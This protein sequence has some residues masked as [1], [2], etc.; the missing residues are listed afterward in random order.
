MLTSH[1]RT[2]PAPVRTARAARF[3]CVAA[4]ALAGCGP[5]A[6]RSDSE[7]LRVAAA[8]DLQTVLPE[9]VEAFARTTGSRR[10]ELVFG[11]S[12]Q[13]ARQLAQGAPVDLFLSADRRFVDELAA[14]GILAADSTRD[15]T[16]GTLCLVVHK[17]ALGV[18]HELADLC[19]EKVGRVAIA[20]PETAPYGRAG[21]QALM[22]A[23]LWDRLEPKI[24]FAENVRQAY[25]F[26][27]TGNAEGGLVGCSIAVTP[28]VSRIDIDPTLHDPIIQRLGRVRDSRHAEAARAFSDFLLGPEA[29]KIFLDHGFR[30]CPDSSAAGGH[31]NSP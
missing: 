1:D 28:E 16:Q 2:V 25:Q 30:P 20:N 14:Q 15:Y 18:V 23:G 3:F 7:P 17:S 6:S 26:V 13:L 4:L 21:K 8:A 31:S 11:A 19:D 5:A 22:A 27:Q 12:G 10:P 9:L 24:V 29:Q